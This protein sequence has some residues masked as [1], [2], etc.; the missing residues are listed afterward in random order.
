MSKFDEKI[1]K[2]V[3]EV[4]ITPPADLMSKI[5]KRRTP[6]YIGMNHIVN[7]KVKYAAAVIVIAAL[8][9]MVYDYSG[10]DDASNAIEEVVSSDNLNNGNND[11]VDNST[12]ENSTAKEETSNVVDNTVDDHM[13]LSTPDNGGSVVNT[14]PGNDHSSQGADAN[15]SNIG[16]QHEQQM[17]EDDQTALADNTDQPNQVIEPG[18]G[19]EELTIEHDATNLNVAYRE[20]LNLL[21]EKDNALDKSK[22]LSPMSPEMFI[23]KQLPVSFI[24]YQVTPWLDNMNVSSSNNLLANRVDEATSQRMTY[25]M[26]ITAGIPISKNLSIH[27]GIGFLNRSENFDYTELSKGKILI[28]D[29]VTGVVHIPGSPDIVKVRYDSTW[30]SDG[31]DKDIN[32]KNRVTYL[33][34]P[35]SLS[36]KVGLSNR[37]S[38][39]LNPGVNFGVFQS[40]VGMSYVNSA[41]EAVY[42]ISDKKSSPYNTGLNIDLQLGL[43]LEYNLNR[44]LNFIVQPIFRK[45]MG[46]VVKSAAGFDQSYTSFGLTTGI[47]YQ[48]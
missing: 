43:G 29:T 3:E 22:K 36:Y 17:N 12:A 13:D 5:R 9:F 31:K 14:N 30:I 27:T 46:S 28:I 39:E 20:E 40:S 11:V 41:N 33:N 7:H 16:T 2:M 26:T 18:S 47:R 23:P 34:I 21:N 10:S 1:A 42:S 15:S 38:L 24:G 45:G 44:R 32:V 8:S 48:L 37:L 25:G 35:V 6:F 4:T 19:P